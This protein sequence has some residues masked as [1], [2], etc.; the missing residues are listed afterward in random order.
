MYF[1]I[2]LKFKFKFNFLKHV[3]R[4]WIL[5]KF[6]IYLKN[7]FIVIVKRVIMRFLNPKVFC[8]KIA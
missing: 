2:I 8:L 7:K 5:S 6:L 1:K 4:I 3:L